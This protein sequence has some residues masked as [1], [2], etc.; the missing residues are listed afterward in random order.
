MIYMCAPPYYTSLK[1]RKDY[2]L[3]KDPLTDENSFDSDYFMT[4]SWP[5]ILNGSPPK[6]ECQCRPITKSTVKNFQFYRIICDWVERMEE[7]ELTQLMMRRQ[8]SVGLMKGLTST[9]PQSGS[10]AN[11]AESEFYC[12]PN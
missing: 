1:R 4:I 5:R 3:D 6:P 10:L 9:K 11:I 8:G 7:R 2:L 12:L